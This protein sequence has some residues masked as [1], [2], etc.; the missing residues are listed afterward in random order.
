MIRQITTM[1][2]SHG[3]R[4]MFLAHVPIRL[5]IATPH[6]S[7]VKRTEPIEGVNPE[8]FFDSGTTGGEGVSSQLVPRPQRATLAE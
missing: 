3:S 4:L 5:R 6:V 2:T 7:S 1:A 8:R